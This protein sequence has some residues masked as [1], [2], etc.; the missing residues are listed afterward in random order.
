MCTANEEYFVVSKVI[1]FTDNCKSLKQD[2]F[3]SK[4]FWVLTTLRIMLL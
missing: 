1:Y 2:R 3:F 4:S